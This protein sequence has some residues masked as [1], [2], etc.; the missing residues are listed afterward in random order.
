MTELFPIRLL[1]SMKRR[2]LGRV[3]QCIYCGALDD[4]TD[5]HIIP[6]ALGGRDEL[7]EASCR[8][9]AN[10][11]SAVELRIAR[12]QAMW[13]LRRALE[14]RSRSKKSQPSSFPV[15]V[16][17]GSDRP[18]VEIAIARYPL[19]V[20]FFVFSPP[21]GEVATGKPAEGRVLIW[22]PRPLTASPAVEISISFS[23]ADVARM[24]A[25]IALGYALVGRQPEDFAEVFVRDLILRG[26][27]R[28]SAWVGGWPDPPLF[29]EQRMHSARAIVD[30]AGFVRVVLQLFRVPSALSQTPV[31]QV[32]V[33]KLR[34]P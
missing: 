9:C 30:R 3:G 12:S 17:D 18:E 32:I 23:A 7:H 16:A 19:L 21:S 2:V 15:R 4:L 26:D 27:A 22:Q 20:P 5:E 14:L 13:P 11:T 28:A 1:P 34:V 29:A 24:L 25:K 10:L 8:V 31:Y 33:G 6:F